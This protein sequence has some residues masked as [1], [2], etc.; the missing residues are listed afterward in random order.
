[1][2]R[3]LIYYFLL[4]LPELS[5]IKQLARSLS[6][7]FIMHKTEDNIHPY[8]FFKVLKKTFLNHPTATRIPFLI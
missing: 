6:H 2:K 5:V 4:I 8:M 3:W 7:I 1:M